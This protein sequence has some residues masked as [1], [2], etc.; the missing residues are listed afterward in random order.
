[1][2]VSEP[3]EFGPYDTN[4]KGV[5][6]AGEESKRVAGM[7][8]VLHAERWNATFAALLAPTLHRAC[9]RRPRSHGSPRPQA[10]R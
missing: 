9:R 6:T 3:T 2:R 10:A 5:P 1:M 4:P 8:T 7:V